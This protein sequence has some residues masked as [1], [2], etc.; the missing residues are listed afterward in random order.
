MIAS[1]A[2]ITRFIKIDKI[3]AIKKEPEWQK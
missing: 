2:T 3:V 1:K